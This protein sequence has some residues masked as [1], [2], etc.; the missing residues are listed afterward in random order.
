MS[1]EKLFNKIKEVVI[2]GYDEDVL[3][4]VKEALEKGVDPAEALEKGLIAGIKVMSDRWAREEVFLTEIFFSAE[5]FKVGSDVLTLEI[6]KLGETRESLGKILLGTVEGDIH[7]LGKNIV[8]TYLIAA[9]FD[10][11]DLGV[12]VPTQV[13]VEKAKELKPDIIGLSALLS[14]T[15]PMQKKVV[16]A[17]KESGLRNKIK[18][19]VGGCGITQEWAEEIGADAFG[20]DALD[21]LEKIKTLLDIQ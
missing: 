17:L 12:D 11:Y 8:G 2:N 15:V 21:A 1:K 10:V 6:E 16:D 7:D 4:W 19:I 20:A 13:F 14:F 18:V 3:K 9:G 5:A